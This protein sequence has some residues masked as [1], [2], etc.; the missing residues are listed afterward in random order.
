MNEV[1]QK[2]EN[3]TRVRAVFADTDG[4]D[5]EPIIKALTPHMLVQSSGGNFHIYWLT[6]DDFPLGQFTL[7]QEA[8]ST[9]FGADD[10]VKDLP[11]VMRLPGFKHNKYDPVDVKL[12]S[13]NP[14][15]PYIHMRT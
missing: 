7:I 11:R 12:L 2:K 4:A 6:V 3:I 14:G 8:I 1:G 10:N 9:N 5:H 13:V 15:H